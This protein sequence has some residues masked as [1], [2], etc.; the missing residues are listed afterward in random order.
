VLPQVGDAGH[1]FDRY[2][3]I[4]GCSDLLELLAVPR[5]IAT[6]HLD[7]ESHGM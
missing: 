1:E 3:R 6:P 2:R 5:R 4:H 7:D